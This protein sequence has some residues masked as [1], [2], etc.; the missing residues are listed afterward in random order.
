LLTVILAIG[1]VYNIVTNIIGD[2]CEDAV[3]E[4]Q[5]CVL[6]YVSVLNIANKRDDQVLL[7]IQLILHLITTIVV[8]LFFHFIRWKVRKLA[9]EAD[10]K[11]VTPSDFT[12]MIEGIPPG[13][14]DNKLEE[15]LEK[16][17]EDG[18]P[19]KVE[20]ITR[21]YKILHYLNLYSQKKH[22]KDQLEKETSEDKKKE[23]TKKINQVITDI[24][25]EKMGIQPT[26]VAFVAFK[27]ASRNH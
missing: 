6:N 1:G 2:G 4:S 14:T 16:F 5:F 26:H 8:M 18:F 27:T 23:I 12:C 20:K 13:V 10:D 22:L 11:T 15:W 19:I 21:A 9:I 7:R 25:Q 17:G 3:D 24:K